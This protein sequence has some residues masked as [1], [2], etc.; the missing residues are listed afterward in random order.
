[1]I[2]PLSITVGFLLLS[3]ALWD[4]F[5]TVVLPRTVDAIFRPARVFYRVGWRL[6]RFVGSWYRNRRARQSFLSAFGPLSVFLLL[7]LWA[8]MIIVAFALL[9]FGLKTQLNVPSSQ[10]GI[11]LF[12]YLS[13]T[14]FFTI[15]LG[16]VV[17][18]NALGRVLIV[19]DAH[20]G[21]EM[22][23]FITSRRNVAVMV[24]KL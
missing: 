9:H 5:S 12:L 14:T 22:E 6:W 17:P 23:R 8:V 24:F 20:I 16:D 18:L 7:G 11:G 10:G 21:F 3:I 4:A 19:A 13:G 2:A 1:M 15:G